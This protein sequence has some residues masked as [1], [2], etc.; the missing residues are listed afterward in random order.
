MPKRNAIPRML[1]F[2]LTLLLSQAAGASGTPESSNAILNNLLTEALAG[3]QGLQA[4]ERRITALRQEIPVA[5]TWEDPR[6]GFGLLAL[7]TD[8]YRFD[9]EPMTQKQITLSQSIP[10]FGK[11]DL[12]T[13]RA[14]LNVVRLEWDLAAKRQVLIRDL[15]DAYYELGF[16]AAS[17]EIN[18]RMIAYLDQI[19]RFAET[20]YSAGKGLQQDILQAQVEH[21]R[22]MDE[23]YMLQR[24]RRALEDR[25]SELLNRSTR[26]AV[27]PP[28]PKTLPEVTVATEQWQLHSL[29]HNPDLNGLKI[30]IEQSAVDI[31]LARKGYYPDPNVV[32]AYGQRDD[33]SDGRD[34]SDF[35]SASV[36][37]TLPVWA[38]NKQE[39]HL[40]AALHRR[41]AARS[42]YRDLAARLPHRIDAL[43]TELV[44]L[45]D[46][47]AL[48]HNAI[49][50][51]ADQ[52]VEAARFSYEVGKADF[53][54]MLSARLRLLSIERQS[55]L[56]LFQFYRKLA[57]LDEILGGSHSV[58]LPN[59]FSDPKMS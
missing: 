11:L 44:Q 12:K 32:L 53:S 40:A 13:R 55:Q 26:Q 35:I 5:G 7:P 19:A 15:S 20:R 30:A 1:I 18:D 59:E 52:W 31:E 4:I 58:S 29:A 37:F 36:S 6:I 45:K 33:A 56:Y 16:V 21:S 22:L 41:D 3:N 49:L 8:T 48:Y 50:V 14:A 2:C 42:Q 43:A 23:R 47:Y 28:T 54:T 10:W 9:Q 17:Q 34:R 39:R 46:S 25:I 38:K 57:V 27:M 24:Q 51:Q